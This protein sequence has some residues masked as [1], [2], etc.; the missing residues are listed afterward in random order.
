MSVAVKTLHL[1][2]HL[3]LGE[4]GAAVAVPHGQTGAYAE[5][6]VPPEEFTAASQL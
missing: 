6:L 1:H 5:H 3:R 2:F 4:C